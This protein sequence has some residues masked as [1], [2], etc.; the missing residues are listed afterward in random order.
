MNS[1]TVINNILDAY[2]ES[3]NN[4]NKKTKEIEERSTGNDKMDNYRKKVVEN[5]RK[6]VGNNK[7]LQFLNDLQLSM[8]GAR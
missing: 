3:G 5:N 8:T 2:K 6:E 4:Y 7:F 1:G